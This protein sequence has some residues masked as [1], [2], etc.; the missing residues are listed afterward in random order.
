MK[1][2]KLAKRVKSVLCPFYIVSHLCSLLSIY[3]KVN[4]QCLS[5][6]TQRAARLSIQSASNAKILPLS[7][8]GLE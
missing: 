1:K 5:Y 3:I 4:P 2:I 7:V 8:F 6:L